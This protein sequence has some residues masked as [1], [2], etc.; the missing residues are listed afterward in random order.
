M[1]GRASKN[2]RHDAGFFHA[3]H[4][5]F[6]GRI[7]DM[8][9]LPKAKLEWLAIPVLAGI[10]T[11]L[12]AYGPAV[13]YEAVTGEQPRDFDQPVDPARASFCWRTQRPKYGCHPD[14]GRVDGAR[15]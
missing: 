4:L 13:I 15:Q 6:S 12:I 8:E 3:R 9:Q 2:T 14:M 5:V 1:S 7:F 11:L 10:S